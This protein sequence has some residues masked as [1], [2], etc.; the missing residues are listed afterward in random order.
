MS[1]T[2]DIGAISRVLRLISL[3]SDHPNL[4]AKE[5]AANLGWPFST[6]HRLLRR[7][8]EAEFAAQTRKGAFTPGPELFRI[9]GRL[10]GQEPLL[11]IAQPLLET[12]AQRFGETALLTV[13]E[14]RAL[15]MYIATSAAPPDPMRYFIE[16][17]RASPLVWGALGRVLLANLSDEEIERAVACPNPPDVKGAPLDPDGLWSHIAEIRSSGFATTHSHRTLNSI[18][19]AVPFFNF[20]QEPVGSIGFQVPAFRYSEGHLPEI[21][22]ALKEAAAVISQQARARVDA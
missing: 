16:L 7:L 12:L 3:L 17:N 2:T 18:G 1:E 21:V 22:A 14:R 13:L 4:S 19:I 20:S 11:R 10:G 6:T 5:A 15:Q 8:L 9:A